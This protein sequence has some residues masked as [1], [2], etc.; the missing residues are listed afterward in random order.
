MVLLR[1]GAFACGLAWFL[2]AG[3]QLWAAVACGASLLALGKYL[4][5]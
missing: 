3:R 4:S 2:F 1:V 5:G